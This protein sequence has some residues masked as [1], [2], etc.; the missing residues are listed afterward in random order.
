MC[1]ARTAFGLRKGRL[2]YGKT[3]IIPDTRCWWCT[4][5]YR[6]G[7][8][9]DYVRQGITRITNRCFKSVK[10]DNTTLG[11]V[12][13]DKAGLRMR[14]KDSERRRGSGGNG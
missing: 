12:L 13:G 3:V 14:Y 4:A 9:I 7:E 1:V 5:K 2:V 8:G 11:I 6:I 10:D